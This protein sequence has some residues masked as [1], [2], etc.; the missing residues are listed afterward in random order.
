M[1]E[2]RTITIYEIDDEE[3]F[4]Y[5]AGEQKDSTHTDAAVQPVVKATID[6]EAGKPSV[7]CPICLECYSKDDAHR[8][9][10]TACGH[11]FGKSCVLSSLKL[12]LEC[13]TCRKKIKR[14]DLIPIY[15][16][17]VLAVDKS[18][19][20][21]LKKELE[22]ERAKRIKAE[23]DKAKCNAIITELKLQMTRLEQQC[24]KS[25]QVFNNVPTLGPEKRTI[26]SAESAPQSYQGVNDVKRIKT[27]EKGSM[28]TFQAL[29]SKSVISPSGI[30]INNSD[31][32]MKSEVVSQH[33]VSSAAY[34]DHGKCTFEV[35]HSQ[36]LI[37]SGLLRSYSHFLLYSTKMESN[38]YIMN[39]NLANP[40]F[41]QPIGQRGTPPLDI[42]ISCNKS[43]AAVV[44]FDNTVNILSL[45]EQTSV[46]GFTLGRDMK[47]YSCAFSMKNEYE[48]HVGSD[49]G[50]ILS[51][52]LRKA[53][54]TWQYAHQSSL[55]NSKYDCEL[56]VKNINIPSQG[57]LPPIVRLLT[58]L[59]PNDHEM[60]YY[61]QN[62]RAKVIHSPAAIISPNQCCDLL[63]DD[64]R[65]YDLCDLGKLTVSSYESLGTSLMISRRIE[66][67]GEKRS[68]HSLCKA[69]FSGLLQDAP[70]RSFYQ[71]NGLFSKAAAAFMPNSNNILLAL[72]DKNSIK[73]SS[74]KEVDSSPVVNTTFLQP[75]RSPVLNCDFSF[76]HENSN[77]CIFSALGK[78]ELK[79]YVRQFDI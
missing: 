70:F 22:E 75:L 34:L 35:F 49:H 4:E 39:M 71:A 8:A 55:K 7:E 18:A 36:S 59:G 45:K 2:N 41:V 17:G 23:A 57:R 78:D 72:Q 38:Y 61:V 50:Y 79:C 15:D 43:L 16:C 58:E 53:E 28:H 77:T 46:A 48:V 9:V 64:N 51:F 6:N 25:M 26:A 76:P 52:D 63:L 56:F 19:E 10:V 66:E 11:V 30:V 33:N 67:H 5:V 69:A 24:K 1:E 31:S 47:G 13:P 29:E 40:R 62:F 20:I 32:Y 65:N 12:K 68:Q 60:L 21:K 74:V 27:E 44:G 14:K 54:G 42:A 73:I 3:D 37:E